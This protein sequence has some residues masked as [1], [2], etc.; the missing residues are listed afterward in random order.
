MNAR[1]LECVKRETKNVLQLQW[2]L[3]LTNQQ[4]KKPYRQIRQKSPKQWGSKEAK[5]K[6]KARAGAKE[7]VGKAKETGD[8][9]KAKERVGKAK[10]LGENLS[11]NKHV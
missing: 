4:S 10:I 7:R 2:R 8:P 3:N 9:V 5:E 6:E 11:I 1:M